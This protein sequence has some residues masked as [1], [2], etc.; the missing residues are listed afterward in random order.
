MC[1][2]VN[3]SHRTEL[4]VCASLHV[5]DYCM[6]KNIIRRAEKPQRLRPTNLIL[7]C[8]QSKRRHVLCSCT[9]YISIQYTATVKR[10]RDAC[11]FVP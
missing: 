1:K 5:S 9:V 3:Q 4:H 10:T 2:C 6:K 7:L 11:R 8:F